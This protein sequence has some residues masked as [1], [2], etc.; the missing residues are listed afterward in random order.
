MGVVSL[1]VLL[2]DE[3]VVGLRLEVDHLVVDVTCVGAGVQAPGVPQALQ[4][5]ARL[6]G[7]ARPGRP[8]VPVVH[9]VGLRVENGVRGQVLLGP[10]VCDIEPCLVI[11]N[12]G[13]VARVES[14]I[15]ILAVADCFGH[16]DKIVKILKT[17]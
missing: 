9:H 8:V 3:R 6:D 14:P 15:K 10:E 4:A 17:R 12:G 1:I 13:E 5:E 16:D 7:E 2:E 11:L